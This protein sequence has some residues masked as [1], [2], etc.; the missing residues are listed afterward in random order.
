MGLINRLQGEEV[1]TSTSFLGLNT[2]RL[3]GMMMRHSAHFI[4]TLTTEQ[5]LAGVRMRMMSQMTSLAMSHPCHQ[6]LSQLGRQQ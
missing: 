6:P 5:L 1:V 3:L 4:L 2:L